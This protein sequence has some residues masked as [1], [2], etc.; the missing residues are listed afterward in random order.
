MV[1]FPI[2]KIIIEGPDLAGKTT[3]YN[4]LHDISKYRWNIQDRSALSMLIYAKM[5]NRDTFHL[6]E[7][8]KK[9]LFNLNNQIILLLPP[10]EVLAKRLQK[11][12][13]PIQNITSLKRLHALFSEFADEYMYLPNVS[14]VKKEIDE[15]IYSLIAGHL[16]GK[17]KHFHIQRLP[18]WCMLSAD[19][20]ESKEVVGLRFTYFDNGEF[21]DVKPELLKY[22]GEKDYYDKIEQQLRNKMFENKLAYQTSSSRR[23]IYHDDSCI[24]LAHF[25]I[26]DQIF[27]AKFFLR[28]SNVKDTLKY[29]INFIHYLTSIVYDVHKCK[30]PVKIEVTLNSA[31]I[32]SKI[33]Q[34]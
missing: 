10:F 34:G 28:S 5:Y 23:I 32:L 12:G 27:D 30:Q 31:H 25:L 13:D 33:D 24:S 1:K 4:K 22:E 11:R 20:Q 19:S 26:R 3:F 16:L 21:S 2:E 15:K 17:E 18:D 7:N 14:V 8:L 6:V 29:D 9:E